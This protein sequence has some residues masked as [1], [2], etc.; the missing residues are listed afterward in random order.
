[1]AIT[2]LTVFHPKYYLNSCSYKLY[3]TCTLN[4]SSNKLSNKN[5]TEYILFCVGLKTGKNM[6]ILDVMIHLLVVYI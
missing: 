3:C 4:N 1:M 5:H 6:E 2:L